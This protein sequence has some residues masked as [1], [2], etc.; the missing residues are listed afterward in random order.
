[1]RSIKPGPRV[2]AGVGNIMKDFKENITPVLSLEE[3]G[4]VLGRSPLINA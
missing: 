3:G 1:M 4:A 2:G